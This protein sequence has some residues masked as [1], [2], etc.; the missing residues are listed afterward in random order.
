VSLNSGMPHPEDYELLLD[1]HLDQRRARLFPGMTLT[2]LPGG[3][4][5]LIGPVTDQ[6]ALHAML[7]RVRD[8]GMPLLLVRRLSEPK[9]GE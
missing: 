1:G 5:R 2:Q 8:L 6:A 4:T 3:E 9:K 7:S